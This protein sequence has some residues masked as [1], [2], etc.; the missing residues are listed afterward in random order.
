MMTEAQALARA[1]DAHGGG[2]VVRDSDG[3]WLWFSVPPEVDSSGNW[4]HPTDDD[5][6]GASLGHGEPCTKAESAASLVAVD[7]YFTEDFATKESE[8]G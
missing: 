8:G 5:N 3:E 1:N 4:R 2:F 6:F 7:G